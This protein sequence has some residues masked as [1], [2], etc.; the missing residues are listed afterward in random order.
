MTKYRNGF[1]SNSS[2]SSFIITDEENI[3]KV[4]ELGDKEGFFDYFELDGVLYTSF[5]SDG[6]DIYGDIS[7]LSNTSVDGSYG[8]PYD[9]E[10]F[11]EFEGERG[12]ESVWIEKTK[13]VDL[14]Q[15]ELKVKDDLYNFIN[16]WLKEYPIYN[17]LDVIDICESNCEELRDFINGI[18]NIVGYCKEE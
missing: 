4:K 14:L 1:V 17:S 18:M 7:K 11:Y 8:V 13:C 3:K 12:V 2:S 16:N 15:V 10:D 6:N 5:I 9:E